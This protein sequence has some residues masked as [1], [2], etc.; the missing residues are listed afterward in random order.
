MHDAR[1]SNGFSH[2]R[3]LD[4]EKASLEKQ[5][6]YI[7]TSKEFY[8]MDKDLVFG[9]IRQLEYQLENIEE[10]HPQWII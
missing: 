1:M 10:E 8:D 9:M 3:R 6:E 4:A 7:K 5:I 2:T